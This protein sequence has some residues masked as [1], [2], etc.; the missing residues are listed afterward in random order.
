[1]PWFAV[2][3]AAGAAVALARKIVVR[4]TRGLVGRRAVEDPELVRT[5]ARFT[6]APGHDADAALLAIAAELSREVAAPLEVTRDAVRGRT[7]DGRSVDIVRISPRPAG[8]VPPGSYTVELTRAWTGAMLGDHARTLLSRVHD[9]LLPI[10]I[11]LAWHWRQDRGFAHP[12]A[13]PHDAPLTAHRQA[14]SP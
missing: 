3:A 5:V 7:D 13:S 11:E 4:H 10:A 2:A 9:A 8:D 6:L 12:H 14:A 1:M